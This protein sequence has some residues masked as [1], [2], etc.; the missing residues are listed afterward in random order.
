MQVIGGRLASIAAEMSQKMIRMSF[1]ILIKESED[2]GCAITD[3]AGNQLAEADTSPLQMGPIPFYVRGAKRIL[4]ERG[5]EIRPGDVIM[6]NSPYH[7]ASHSP[8]IGVLVPVFR[9][10]LLVAFAVTT[11]HHMDIG[12][13]K[14]GTSV[15]DAVDE[16]AGGLRLLA[17][18][19]REEGRENAGVWRMIADNVRIP[20]L[21]IGDLRAQLAAAEIGA[22]RLNELFDE[23][24]VDRVFEA[25]RLLEDYSERMLRQQIAALP[26]GEYRGRASW[27]ALPTIPPIVICRSSPRCASPAT[28]L[29]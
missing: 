6:H 1:S 19:V 7:G 5:E 28:R 22:A 4:T 26:D 23:I 25:Q 27:T 8:D 20:D 14:P 11:A 18:K 3:A 2:I 15:I 9:D 13:A 29:R 21:V 24:G 10:S 17:L 12:C 16:W